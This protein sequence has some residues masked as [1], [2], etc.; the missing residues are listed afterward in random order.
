MT[1]LLWLA[2]TSGPSRHPLR[3]DPP[4]RPFPYDGPVAAGISVP[5][6]PRHTIDDALTAAYD[7]WAAAYLAEAAPDADGP[8]WRVKMNR[9]ANAPT[10]SESQGYGMLLTA[11]FAG[12]DPAAR[13]RFDGL[14][15]YRL[16]H[17]SV[18]DPRLMD[19]EVPADEAPS[20]DDDSAFDGDADAAYAL[21]LADAQWGSDE[22]DYRA[23]AETVLA[24]LVELLGAD[25]HQPLLGD[26]VDPDGGRYS[27]WTPRSSDWMPESFRVFADATGDERWTAAVDAAYAAIAQVQR[28]HSPG[29]GLLPDFL[30]RDGAG[31]APAP[32][33]FLESD[34]DGAYGYNA[35]RDPWR[36]GADAFTTGEPRAVAALAPLAAWAR[37]ETGGDPES[38]GS[39]YELD[40]T[41][42]PGYRYSSS[43]YVGPMLVA[44]AT[45]PQGQAWLDAGFAA[46]ADAR[47]G[48][49]EDS[50]ALLSLLTVSGRRWTP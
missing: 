39:G 38:L 9:T 17:S 20:P 32:P 47:E 35:C 18:L 6:L 8:T 23:D 11:W 36:I 26:W 3:A 34:H 29:T 48:Y 24:G 4:Y 1:W 25:S 10:T 2:C 31:Y 21:L 30:V 12:H 43:V 5:D 46:V 19:W 15:R 50:V 41:L 33:G 14:R 40:G 27:Q 45:D 37:A 42:I 44:Q 22:V 7:D 16:R 28:D 13:E 49:F